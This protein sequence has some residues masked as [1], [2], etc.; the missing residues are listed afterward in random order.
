M[1]NISQYSQTAASNNA[2]PPNGWPEGQAPSTV[3]DCAREMM[4]GLAKWYAS[5]K[6][7]LV[8]TG[9]GNAYALSTGSSHAALADIGTVVFRANHSNTGAATLAVDGLTSKAIRSR[10]A[11]LA[12]GALVADDLYMV[13]YNGTDD[14]FDMVTVPAAFNQLVAGGLSYPTADG[15]VGQYLTTN[16]AGV[17][18]FANAAQNITRSARTSNTILGAGDK[19]AIID[20]TSGTF[21]Q[22]LTAA[23][24]LGNG[25]YCYFKNSGTG[26]ITLDP[27]GAETIAG[28]ATKIVFPGEELLIQCDG[29]GFNVWTGDKRFGSFLLS[30]QTASNSATVDFTGISSAY[31]EYEVHVLN[32]VPA[33]DGTGLQL[34]TSANAGSSY[35]SGATDYKNTVT[36]AAE[37][38]LCQALGS[39]T[40]EQGYSGVVRIYRPSE[41]TFTVVS[42]EGVGIN[43]SGVAVMNSFG[44]YRASA[45]AVDA[46]RFLMSSGN[47]ESGIFK[48]YGLR[49]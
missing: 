28:A 2:A 13:T 31:D 17:L 47:I 12:S 15:T 26:T 6:G 41:S 32:A 10:G 46:V 25:W 34:R 22:T 19:S 3:N 39:D 23:A 42:A 24:T 36:D 1:S 5:L 4:A 8:T 33:N 38:A 49:K 30:T 43:Q 20:V 44:G 45:A 21:T 9:T 29:T 35:D 16:G 37:I 40:N 14:A 48:L 27:D 18:S 11:A 7:S